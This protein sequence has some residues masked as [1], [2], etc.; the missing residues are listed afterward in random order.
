MS[1]DTYTFKVESKVNIYEK[2]NT[3]AAMEIFYIGTDPNYCGFRIGQGLVTASLTFA[4]ELRTSNT[5]NKI[6]PDVA[7]GIFTSNYSQRIAE[8]LKFDWLETVW[9][10][11]FTY[12]SKT[13]A[14]RIGDEHKSAK[15]GALR[16]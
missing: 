14:E 9:Y 10:S 13:M 8:V 6:I 2:Y 1:Y 4:R 5:E 11:D 7:F 12:W 3:C 16:L 15:L